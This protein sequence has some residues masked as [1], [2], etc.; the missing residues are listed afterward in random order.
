MGH[1][2]YCGD[3]DDFFGLAETVNSIEPNAVNNVVTWQEAIFPYTKNRDIY[4][5][6]LESSPSGIGTTKI[7]QQSLY[8][9]VV[10]SAPAAA[11]KMGGALDTI[12][13]WQWPGTLG[14]NAYMDGIFGYVNAANGGGR[15]SSKSQNNVENISDVILVAD[16]GAYDMG[17]LG[18]PAATAVPSVVGADGS[19]C[20][21]GGTYP[22]SPYGTGSF[23]AG[24][25]PRKNPSGAYAGGK[26]CAYENGE[27]GRVTFAAVDGSAKT[28]DIK[29]VYEK[30]TAGP[31]QVL[32]HMYT[33]STN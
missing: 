31:N 27:Q 5:S 11:I 29:K 12:Y 15:P 24:P 13:G 1:I 30:R 6:P 20:V 26:K 4:V 19:Y 8:Y 7:F 22:S 23:I 16:A 3:N 14:G 9:G 21:P 25:W 32:Y 10:P 2:Q 33:G 17:L 28:M 18:G